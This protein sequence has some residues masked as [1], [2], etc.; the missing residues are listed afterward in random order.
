[1]TTQT[2]KPKFTYEDYCNTPDDER[3]ELL[4]GELVMVPAPR[5]T[6]QFVKGE[7]FT[8]LHSHAR[9]HSLGHIL[10][11]PTDVVL[12]DTVVLQPDILFVS[13]ERGH[14]ITEANV[15][16]APDLVVEVLSPSTAERDTT[17]KRALYYRHGVREFWLV[18]TDAKTVAVLLRGR[19]DFESVGQYSLGDTLTSPALVGFSLGLG[20]IFA[21]A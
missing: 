15:Q 1:M 11:A 8:A 2:V 7:I 3:Y 20:E 18:D 6:H 13:A 16:G 21:M 4:D 17:T 10:D 19:S 14:I 9:E 12:S 5:T